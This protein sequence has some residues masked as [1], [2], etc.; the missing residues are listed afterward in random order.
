MF[1]LDCLHCLAAILPVAPAVSSKKKKLIDNET[2]LLNSSMFHFFCR[3]ITGKKENPVSFFNNSRST[4]LDSGWH[5]LNCT[6]ARTQRPSHAIFPR[7]PIDPVSTTPSVCHRL[8]VMS[9][10]CRYTAQRCARQLRVAGHARPSLAIAPQRVA[11]RH[12]ST[13]AAVDPKISSIVDQIS[14]LTLLETASLVSSLK[15]S[16]REA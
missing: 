13:E 15:V 2:K 14:Q 9:M 10:T 3:P 8:A 12:N 16:G 11:R 1:C 6:R 4:Q 7:H 5:C